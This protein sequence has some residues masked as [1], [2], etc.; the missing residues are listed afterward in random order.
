MIIRSEADATA[1]D[2]AMELIDLGWSIDRIAVALGREAGWVDQAIDAVVA[3]EA[4]G[5][6][7]N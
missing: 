1:A 5:A 6:A 2:A 4:K 7:L 3:E